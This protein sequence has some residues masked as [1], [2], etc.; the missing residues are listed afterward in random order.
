MV[1]FFW[2]T[3][4]FLNKLVQAIAE[5]PAPLTTILILF[6]DFLL[7]SSALMSA[8]VVIIAVPCWSS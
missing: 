1:I 2:G 8:A 3:P 5:A 7:I 6:I 4:L